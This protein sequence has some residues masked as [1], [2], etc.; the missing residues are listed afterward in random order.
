MIRNFIIK[1]L[2]LD[3]RYVR[4]DERIKVLN[5]VKDYI[6]KNYYVKKHSKLYEIIY[7]LECQINQGKFIAS[8]GFEGQKFKDKCHYKYPLVNGRITNGEDRV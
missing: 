2:K 8:K 3:F 1:L 5:E 4:L 6:N 7:N